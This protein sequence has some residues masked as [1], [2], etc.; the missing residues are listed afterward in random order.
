VSAP[1]GH[2]I[3]Q[4]GDRIYVTAASDELTQLLKNLGIITHK[5][6]RVILCGG[7]KVGFYLAQQ[8]S[9]VG[10]QVELI[11]KDYDRCLELANYL[12][13]VSIVH[14]D[15]SSQSFLESEGIEQCDALVALTSFD[16]MNIIISLYAQ[17]YQVNQVVTKVDHI[18]DSTIQ[19]V[20]GLGSV[21]CPKELCCNQIVRYV[22]AMENTKGSALT[23]HT[24]AEGQM[25]ALE[26]RADEETMHCGEPLRELTLKK[27]VLIA[28]ITRS[29]KPIIPN[30]DTT[31][32][33]GD[34]IV[35]VTSGDTVLHRFNDIFA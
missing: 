12:P 17:N 27:N 2:F 1:D 13:G 32:Q 31:F 26:F 16:E 6:K 19:D 14:G 24:F 34:T 22:R 18:E 9:R 29:R 8:L 35:V 15:A 25:E 21:V 11:E 10:V 7:G 23:V 30:G 28:A 20:L 33:R 3:L 5:V 4:E